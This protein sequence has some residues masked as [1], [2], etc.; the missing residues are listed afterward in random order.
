MTLGGEGGHGEV[1]RTPSVSFHEDD[2]QHG[3][4]DATDPLLALLNN[5]QMDRMY[6]NATF[7]QSQPCSQAS[8]SYSGH[9]TTE[10][11]PLRARIAS[12]LIDELAPNK[13]PSRL[14]ETARRLN[15]FAE[16]LLDPKNEGDP[17]FQAVLGVYRFFDQ[18]FSILGILSVLHMHAGDVL[19]TV[20]ALSRMDPKD[21]IVDETFELRS[22]EASNDDMARY[23]RF[24]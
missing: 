22:I 14:A 21:V 12:A 11:P 4:S 18:K 19:E 9:G 3:F 8:D 23:F 6:Q 20:A 7:T 13:A 15:E 2:S 5:S 10:S 17:F 1:E 24:D 16:S